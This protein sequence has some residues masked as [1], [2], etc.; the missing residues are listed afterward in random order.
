[1]TADMEALVLGTH[2]LVHHKVLKE[3][4]KQ[5]LVVLGA[6]HVLL[7]LMNQLV[8][9]TAVLGT[10]LIATHLM[11]NH[12]QVVKV[13]IVDALG[14]EPI[15]TLSTEQIRQLVKLD[16][17]VALGTVAVTYVTVFMM[18]LLFVMG[19]M[20]LHARA[21]HVQEISAAVIIIME[22]VLEHM[23]HSAKEQQLAQ[24]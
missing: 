15:V 2:Q 1:M 21:T 5:S 23:A 10:F 13:V 22:I 8:Q 16:I 17:L 3:H 7:H 19:N 24:I 4:A 14:L 11:G 9:E 6:Q 12:K 20:I 18:K